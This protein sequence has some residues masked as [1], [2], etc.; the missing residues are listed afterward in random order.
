MHCDMDTRVGTA[1]TYV[2]QESQMW[3]T[4]ATSFMRAIC[5]LSKLLSESSYLDEYT[6]TLAFAPHVSTTTCY[7]RDL[8]SSYLTYNT[9]AYLGAEF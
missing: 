3:A 8:S 5:Q 6:H 1:N 7:I 4:S 2:A 9:V